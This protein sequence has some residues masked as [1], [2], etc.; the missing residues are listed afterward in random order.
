[1]R[2]KAQIYRSGRLLRTVDMEQAVP[3]SFIINVHHDGDDTWVSTG[4]GLGWAIG[5]DYYAGL[6][7]SPQWLEQTEKPPAVTQAKGNTSLR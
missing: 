2:G 5:D 3:H 6:Q 7:K 1:L 4:K